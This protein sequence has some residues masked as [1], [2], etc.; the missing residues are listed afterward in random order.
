MQ[1]R[2]IQECGTESPF[3]NEFWDNKRD[4]IYVDI[5]SGELLFSSLDKFDSGTGW[6]SF[7]NLLSMTILLP[8]W[9]TAIT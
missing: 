5:I 8:K 9:I 2:V 4:G 6:P 3:R 1:S 7:A